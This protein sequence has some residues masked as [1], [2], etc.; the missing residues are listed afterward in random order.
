M[1]ILR[2]KAA[3]THKTIKQV[4]KAR[5]R[6]GDEGAN[7]IEVTLK[8]ARIDYRSSPLEKIKKTEKRQRNGDTQDM[9]KAT[10]YASNMLHCT[11][12]EAPKETRNMQ[13]RTT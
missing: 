10:N 1:A 12:C 6:A 4:I 8:T 2:Q 9:P 3:C 7:C 5:A 13:L 11:V